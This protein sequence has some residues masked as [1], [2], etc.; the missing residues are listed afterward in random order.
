MYCTESVT[1]KSMVQYLNVSNNTVPNNT[2]HINFMDM[3]RVDSPKHFCNFFNDSVVVI[4]LETLNFK[5]TR[6]SIFFFHSKNR[7]TNFSRRKQMAA[8]TH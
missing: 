4:K 8:N 1:N 2:R 7:Q 5:Q 6:Y 3:N